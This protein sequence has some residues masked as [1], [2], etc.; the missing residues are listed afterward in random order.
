MKRTLEAPSNVSSETYRVYCG[1]DKSLTHRAIMFASLA[2]GTS[3]VLQPLLGADCLSTL[4]CFQALGVKV[5]VI[6]DSPAR[7]IITSMGSKHFTQPT[8][9]L[10]CGNSGTTVRLILGILAAQKSLTFRLVGDESLS[11]R[12]MKR[13]VGPLRAMGASI[14]GPGDG[15]FLPLTVH[16]RDLR[17]VAHTIDKASAQIKSSL[18]LAGL[19]CRGTTH[20]ELPKGSR[21]HT[22][23]VLQTMGAAIRTSTTDTLEVI[24]LAGP[25]VVKPMNVSI[26]VDPSS[27]A[28]FAGLGLLKSQGLIEMPEV[29]D[30][31]TR[32]GFMNVLNRMS[33]GLQFIRSESQGFVEPVGLLSVKG[34]LPLFGTTIDESEVPTLVDEIPLL[35]VVAAFAKGPSLFRGLSELRV[36]ESDRLLLTA[37]LLEAAGAVYEIRGDDLW[38]AGGLEAVKPFTFDPKG[39]HRLAMA[40]AIMAR[41]CKKPCCILD[42]ECVRVSFPNFYEALDAVNSF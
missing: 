13:V 15:N 6:T 17:P 1:R 9:D 4:S 14:E 24:D 25:F 36:K 22:E 21:D 41:R 19:F 33:K 5:D 3:T 35:A 2:E 7:V 23:R 29:L 31:P 12:P 38:I 18:L 26:P 34:G 10:D 28:F 11:S 40:A 32:T 20:V 8:R 16:G 42:S 30:N 37:A 39:D 27:A